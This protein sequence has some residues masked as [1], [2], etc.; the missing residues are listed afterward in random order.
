MNRL[1]ETIKISPPIE[2]RIAEFRADLLVHSTRRITRKHLTFGS[3]AV[4]TEQQHYEL[5]EEVSDHFQLHPNEVYVVGSAKLGFSIAP[6]KR[7]RPFCDESDIDLAIISDTLFDR[8]WQELFDYENTQ[9]SW[10][11]KGAF[12]QYFFRG[13]IRPDKFP[14]ATSFPFSNEWTEF[15]R[16]LTNS[17]RYGDIKISAGIYRNWKFFEDYQA[18]CIEKCREQERLRNEDNRHE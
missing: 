14:R 13:W 18:I 8:V 1:G 3:C 7:F 12:V 10:P 11:T 9:S 16:E 4:L 17:R 2:D 6:A 5:K 15:F